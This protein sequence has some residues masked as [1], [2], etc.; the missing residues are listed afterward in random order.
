M[1]NEIK[2]LRAVN[3]PNI[4]K[5][6]EIIDC[7]DV[8]YIVMEFA[9]GGPLINLMEEQE[10]LDEAKAKIYFHQLVSAVEYL[11]SLN[12]CHRDI[13]LE[14]IL[15]S[16][17]DEENPVLKLTDMGLGKFADESLLKTIC[18]TRSYLAPEVV[19]SAVEQDRTPYTVK[20]RSPSSHFIVDSLNWL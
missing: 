4:I 5:L 14:N 7:E 15:I 1:K 2:I 19:R 10:R 17:E 11:H 16:Y 20:A 3:H 8:L 12:I 18:G 6:E 9:E 13:K